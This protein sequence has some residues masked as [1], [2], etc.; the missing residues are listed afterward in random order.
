MTGQPEPLPRTH[1][2]A[3]SLAF[4]RRYGGWIALAVA[5]AVYHRRFAKESMNFADY[6]QGAACLLDGQPMLQCA[7]AFP[8]T[9]V[10]ALVMAPF[11]ALSPGL[12][13]LVWYA[14][15]IAATVA[16]FAISETLARR[17]YP[18]AADGHRLLWL[19]VLAVVLGVKFA[20]AVFGF[21]A[22]DTPVFMLLLVGLWGLSVGR[23][24]TA[25]ATLA[26]AA[27]LKATPLIFFPYLLLKRR[28]L[29]AGVFAAVFLAVSLLPDVVAA[30]KG[31][32]PDYFWTW[33]RQIAGPTLG[34]GAPLN[35]TVAGAWSY[36]TN[37]Q[38][39]HGL[40]ALATARAG[41]ADYSRYADL[42]ASALFLLAVGILL[43]KSPRRD[44]FVGIDGG[45]L[46]IAMVVLSP[47]TSR[48]HYVVL[49]L[50]YTMLA[51]AFLSDHR[52]RLVG[53]AVL[54][55]SFILVTATSNDA[56][57][58]WLSTVSREYGFLPLGAAVLL[59]YFAAI[60][61]TS[62]LRASRRAR[63]AG[64]IAD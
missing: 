3:P 40:V 1:G 16:C 49:I 12:Q 46:S 13:N 32:K 64:A 50:P 31:F 8:Y 24:V 47:M 33:L 23:P 52:T 61:W 14:I 4:A 56:V 41:L 7:P 43:I 15:L 42:V 63:E 37:N 39:L 29:A 55:L 6:V 5:V 48:Y 2:A 51:A 18:A 44:E 36:G 17:L 38:S 60:I 53:G 62:P 30:L 19:R 26:L 11:L 54:L 21:H 57:G 25:G 34:G 22:H 20:L 10:F 27:A 9:P 28:F 45:I 58:S 59:I 35:E